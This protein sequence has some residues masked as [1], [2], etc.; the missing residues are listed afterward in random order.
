[1]E[2]DKSP[3]IKQVGQMCVG[4]VMGHNPAPTPLQSYKFKK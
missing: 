1:M 4:L 3:F 2:W